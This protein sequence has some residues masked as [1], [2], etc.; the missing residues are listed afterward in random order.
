[1]GWRTI[2]DIDPSHPEAQRLHRN[3]LARQR[4]WR[5]TGWIPFPFPDGTDTEHLDWIQANL[6]STCYEWQGDDD[7]S[8]WI[9][10]LE[11]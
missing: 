9:R 6:G 1:M 8:M 11:D 2:E 4:R 5:K 10:R 7:G 3:R